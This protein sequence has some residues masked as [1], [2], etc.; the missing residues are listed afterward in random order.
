MAEAEGYAWS[1]C[2]DDKTVWETNRDD[3]QVVGPRYQ[4]LTG[5]AGHRRLKEGDV[6]VTVRAYRAG[7]WSK[8]SIITITLRPRAVKR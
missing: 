3:G 4:L 2:Q 7:R 1:F 6:D 8:P 5:S